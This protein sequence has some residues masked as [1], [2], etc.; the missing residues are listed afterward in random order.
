MY[1]KSIF[2]IAEVG[3]LIMR[4]LHIVCL[5]LSHSVS[6][7]ICTVLT[8]G[9]WK[10]IGVI[11]GKECKFFGL[12]IIQ[13]SRRGKMVVG[14][15]VKFVSRFRSNMVGLMTPCTIQLM[16][17]GH[18]EIG[19]DSGFSGVV[20]SCRDKITIGSRVKVGG[21]V[22]IFDH[23]YHSL[24][25]EVRSSS[26]DF[27]RAKSCPIHIGDD[28]FIGTNAIVLKGAM[29]GAR[30]I[31]GAGAVVS[32]SVPEDSIVVGNPAEVIRRT[33]VLVS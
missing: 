22:R 20:I 14:S 24:D 18:L 9:Y 29:I 33:S 28:V 21:N 12:P 3:R 7:W 10:S 11:L 19:D 16:S 4:I 13:L 25:Y 17:D 15:R 26:E 1:N 27:K 23:D 31:I 2:S 30:S 5:R 6:M 32:G 8:K